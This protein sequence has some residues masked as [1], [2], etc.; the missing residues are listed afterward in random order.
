MCVHK[1][2][3]R[4]IVQM[5][6]GFFFVQNNLHVIICLILSLM[7]NDLTQKDEICQ[8]IDQFIPYHN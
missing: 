8:H 7:K 1:I 6:A 3:I 5:G 2:V 4:L